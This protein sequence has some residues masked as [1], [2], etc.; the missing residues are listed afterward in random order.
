[1]KVL[2][3]GATGFVGS[4]ILRLLIE[5]G[6]EALA[7]YRSERKLSLLDGLTVEAVQGDL[8]DMAALE[9]ACAGCDAVIHTA[10]KADYWKDDDRDAL[11][12]V[13]VDGTRNVMSAAKAAGVRRV[14]FTSSA[15]AIGIRPGTKEADES[16][17][18]NL[19]PERFWY[20][21]TKVKAEEVVAEFAADGL[22]VVTLNPTV[23]I[24]PGDINAIS[25]SF[26]LETARLQWLV[27]MSRGGLAVIDVRD[28]AR[29]HV[30]ALD[31]GR[32][33]E[34]YILNSANLSYRQWF[35]LIA[36]ACDVRAPLFALP[37]WTLEPTARLI[38]LLRALG[39]QTPMD[40]NQTR[41]GGTHV[42][43]DGRKAYAELFTPAIDISTSLRETFKWYQQNGYIKR[44]L[45]TRL[46]ASI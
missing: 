2:V 14:I 30:N 37:D 13:N 25:G 36:A 20:A 17:A 16:D 46:I 10:A 3:T 8:S 33:G 27:P 28:V 7:L 45:L 19:A 41:L 35:G 44:G 39:A 38:E 5:E 24:G 11:W 34:R 23:I 29:A 6:H 22:D 9:R 31:R 1:M 26:I 32:S 18:F 4:H 12:R 42:Y 40:A 21:H 15:S 43:F